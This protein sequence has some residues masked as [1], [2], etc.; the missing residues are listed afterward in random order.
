MNGNGH[1]ER[2]AWVILFSCFSVWVGIIISI[3]LLGSRLIQTASRPLPLSLQVNQGTVR[4]EGNQ[5]TAAIFMGDLPAET[6]APANIITSSGDAATLVV[7]ADE[8]NGNGEDENR[9]ILGRLQI[10]GDTLVEIEQA[11]TPRF[12]LSTADRHMAL[13]LNSG[14]MRIK[15]PEGEGRPFSITIETPQGLVYLPQAGQ[16]TVEVDTAETQ[17]VALEGEAMLEANG[18]SLTLQADERGMIPQEGVPAGPLSTERNL[19]QNGDFSDGLNAWD[20]LS[21]VVDISGQPAG[22]VEVVTDSGEPAL[23]FQRVGNGHADTGVR[24]VINQEVSD[25]DAIRLEISL[26]ILDQSL[27]VCGSVGSECPLT[28]RVEYEDVN[29]NNQVWYQ[30][31][32][33]NG[34][35]GSNGTPDVCVTCAPPRPGHVQIT[36]GQFAFYRGDLLSLLPQHGAPLPGRIKNVSL[37]AA[38]HSFALDVLDVSLI[39]EEAP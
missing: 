16:Y 28:L 25:F 12:N 6:E 24:Q 22:Q 11:T 1:R 17:L 7:Y 32:F 30:G 2:L 3:P 33:A 18:D 31:F 9:Q 36:S 29:G 39:V 19:V 14:R 34:I 20:Q 35:P 13:K 5:Q 26:R 27:A 10:F 23:R 8:G 21:W 38:G 15:L 4:L 37:L